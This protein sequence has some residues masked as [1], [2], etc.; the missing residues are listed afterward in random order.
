[1]NDS[2]SLVNTLSEPLRQPFW[3]AALAS[4]GLHGVLGVNAPRISNLIYGGNSSKNLPGSVG[5]VEL[6]PAEVGRLPQSIPPL[7]SKAKTPFSL[8]APVPLPRNITPPL[9]PAPNPINLPALPPGMPPPGFF[10]PAPPSPLPS[11][12]P[13]IPPKAPS[14]TIQNPAPQTPV[15]IIPPQP[16]TNLIPPPSPG[17]FSPITPPPPP[18]DTQ[19]PQ[20]PGSQVD[21]GE[22]LEKLRN[23][24]GRLPLFPDGAVVYTPQFPITGTNSESGN[25]PQSTQQDPNQENQITESPEERARRQQFEQQQKQLEQQGNPGQNSSK[26]S[27]RNLAAATTYIALFERFKKAYPDLEMTGPTPVNVPYPKT[28][29]SQKLEGKAVF[30]AVVNPQ[31]LLRAEPQ[32]I[33][34]TGSNILDDAAKFAIINPQF[35]LPPAST[36]KLYQLAVAFKYDEKVCSGIPVTPSATPATGPLPSP[37]PAAVPPSPGGVKPQFEKPPRD[38]SKPK[39]AVKP[40]PSPQPQSTAKPSPSPQPKPEAKPSVSPSASPQLKPG[41]RDLVLPEP[42]PVPTESPI[43]EPQPVPTESPIPEPVVSP[44]T[45]ASPTASPSPAASPAASPG[46]EASPTTEASPTASPSP[47]ASP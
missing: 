22:S 34:L 18:S 10:A 15:A 40:L 4:I 16:P 47:A 46:A 9:P 43:P 35:I 23:A 44:T 12:T 29:C 33:A 32:T 13:P 19:T 39:P 30:G 14:P 42:E 38:S 26:D 45:E 20:P 11:L 8:V 5:F 3:W 41:A 25:S 37:A 24:Q 2:F 21:E 31:G 36:H 27:D 28:A 7:A 6:T 17:N 1:M